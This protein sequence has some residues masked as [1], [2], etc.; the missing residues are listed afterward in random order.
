MPQPKDAE[1]F[2]DYWKGQYVHSLGQFKYYKNK[3][4]SEQDSKKKVRAT[5][6]AKR[7]RKQVKKASR[8]VRKWLQKKDQ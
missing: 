5:N 8:R 4:A 3:A 7:C 1:K 2:L 6:Q